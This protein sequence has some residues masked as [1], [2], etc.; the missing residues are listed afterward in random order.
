MAEMTTADLMDLMA[1]GITLHPVTPI[2]ARNS[3]YPVP[4]DTRALLRA[5][6]PMGSETIVIAITI[7]AGVSTSPAPK[8]RGARSTPM[9]V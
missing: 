9:A 6:N 1:I 2:P 4:S 7:A 8:T 5:V 3:K